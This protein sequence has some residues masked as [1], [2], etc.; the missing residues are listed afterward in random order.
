MF[1]QIREKKSRNTYV[2][3]TNCTESITK[4]IRIGLEKYEHL[5]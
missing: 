3:M 5:I 1:N 4:V 2:M